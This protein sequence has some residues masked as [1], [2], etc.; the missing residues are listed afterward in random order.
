MPRWNG[1]C[2]GEPRKRRFPTLT[3]ANI[4]LD[5]IWRYAIKSGHS[6][7]KLP[8][9]SYTCRICGGYHHTSQPKMNRS[10]TV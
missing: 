3:A 5:S 8:C 7:G 2:T 9:R 1:Y 10:E 6:T 4:A